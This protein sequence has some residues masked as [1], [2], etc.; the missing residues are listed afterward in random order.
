MEHFPTIGLECMMHENQPHSIYDRVR[1]LGMGLSKPLAGGGRDR[2]FATPSAPVG[3]T[4]LWNIFPGVFHQQ[5]DVNYREI[6]RAALWSGRA[7]ARFPS[8]PK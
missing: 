6:R 4:A 1:I 8:Y 5:C 3:D 7:A 2:A